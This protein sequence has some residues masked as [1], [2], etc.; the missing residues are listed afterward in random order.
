MN[1]NLDRIAQ[2]V[3][4]DLEEV[5]GDFF[6]RVEQINTEIKGQAK[7][8]NLY[9][10]ARLPQATKMALVEVLHRDKSTKELHE[11]YED[12]LPFEDRQ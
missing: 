2:Q 12:M 10:V 6:E 11:I 5:A 1:D 7:G 4:F 9:G 3:Y 8:E